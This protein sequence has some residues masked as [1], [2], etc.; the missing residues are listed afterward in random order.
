[1]LALLT[2]RWAEY[3]AGLPLTD[4][5]YLLVFGLGYYAVRRGPNGSW[6]LA[7]ALL[8]GPLAK[9]SFVFLLPWL[10]W[11][12]HKTLSWPKQLLAI[13][14]GMVA[15]LAVHHLVD[16]R[17][18]APATQSVS[19]AVAH[20][21]NITYSLGRAASPK[22]IGELLSI[23]GLFTLIVPIALWL[24][25]R[26]NQAA[27]IS[28]YASLGWAEVGLLAVVAVHMLLSGD[29]GRMGYLAA[30]AFCSALALAFTYWRRLLRV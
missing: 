26:N 12:G 20:F 5:L 9:E 22:G 21:G 8:M 15:L 24:E 11:F 30:P 4:S 25:K 14:V 27:S 29:L 28:I 13:A 6:A 3:A 18:A 7:A 19:N 17:I 1:M 23:F 2:S 10:F 16:S